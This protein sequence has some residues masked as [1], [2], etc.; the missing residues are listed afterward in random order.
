[1]P[2]DFETLPDLYDKLTNPPYK[3]ILKDYEF[4]EAIHDYLHRMHGELFKREVQ[5]GNGD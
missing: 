5:N 4:E 1:M 2:S 3:E